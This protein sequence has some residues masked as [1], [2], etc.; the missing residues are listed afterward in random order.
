MGKRIDSGPSIRDHKSERWVFYDSTETKA[1]KAGVTASAGD[2][3]WYHHTSSANY[4]GGAFSRHRRRWHSRQY[5]GLL[6]TDALFHATVGFPE[7]LPID[8]GKGTA[9]INPGGGGDFTSL[10]I[11]V[12]RT[13]REQVRFGG[14]YNFYNK[15]PLDNNNNNTSFILY[16]N[17]KHYVRDGNGS[18]N[19]AYGERLKGLGISEVAGT[20]TPTDPWRVQ[21][22][23]YADIDRSN[24]FDPAK[25]IL[26]KQMYSHVAGT[27]YYRRD[28]KIEVGADVPVSDGKPVKA[29]EWRD[30]Y[31]LGQSDAGNGQFMSA[32]NVLHTGTATVANPEAQVWDA[33]MVGIIQ[34]GV[35]VEDAV[36]MGFLQISP[37]YR[38]QARVFHRPVTRY[39]L[40]KVGGDLDNVI[41][42]YNYDIGYTIQ[43]PNITTTGE[44][45]I[46][47]FSVFNKGPMCTG[48]RDTDG[49]GIPDYEDLD[50]DGDG[51]SDVIEAGL[52]ED[53]ANPGKLLP[54]EAQVTTLPDANGN[55]NPDV[56][57]P[58]PPAPQLTEAKE[59]REPVK[60]NINQNTVT[61]ATKVELYKKADDGTLT[62]V[63]EQT[64]AAGAT[65][66]YVT[67]IVDLIPGDVLV[68]KE[69]TPAD[70][71]SPL[72]N[73]IIVKAIDN[74]A[75]DAPTV[76][77]PLADGDIMISVVPTEP[78]GTIKVYSDTLLI[79]EVPVPDDWV[80]GQP[81]EVTLDLASPLRAGAEVTATH[82]DANGNISAPSNPVIVLDTM[83]IYEGGTVPQGYAVIN[84]EAEAGGMIVGPGQVAA[85]QETKISD[86]MAQLGI[87]AV[88]IDENTYEANG[89]DQDIENT[90]VP[91]AG[92][93]ITALFKQLPSADPVID[94]VG[95]L[96]TKVTGTGVN[97][98]TIEVEFPD[99]TKV[100]TTVVDGKWSVD[101]PVGVDLKVD[102]KV[103]ATQ[104]EDGKTTA[105]PVETVVVPNI[106][107]N[108]ADPNTVPEGYVKGTF[109][110]GPNGS[111]DGQTSP[112]VM[113]AKVN[114]TKFGDLTLP[115]PV[116][117][118]G[119]LSDDWAPVLPDKT[120]LITKNAD[121]TAVF[122]KNEITPAPL[123]DPI[124]DLDKT[125]TAT[126]V[127]GAAITGT[128]K[129]GDVEHVIPA[130]AITVDGDGKVTID[131]SKIT[132]A[133]EPGGTLPADAVVSLSAKDGTKEASD[134]TLAVRTVTPV[135][136]PNP[137]TSKDPPDGYSR[138]TL[139]PGNHGTFKEGVVSVF[140]VKDGTPVTAITNLPTAD[141]ITVTNPAYELK[142]GT[143]LWSP[144]LPATIEDA[145]NDRT[146]TAQYNQLTSAKPVITAPEAGTKTVEGTGVAG[147]TIVVTFPNG[148]KA[149]TTVKDDGTWTV[150]S[151]V[152]LKVDE[153]INATQTET[154]KISADA[155]EV[156]VVN[157]KAPEPPTIV[158]PVYEGQTTVIV[159]PTEVV[160]RIDLY[161][162]G[163]V[164]GS[165]NVTAPGNVAV[166]LNEGVTLA[167][168]DV[169]T[170]KH[171]DGEH[172]SESDPVTVLPTIIPVTDPATTP[173]E[174]F[175]RVT[176]NAADGG[177]F[178]P[179]VV[180]LFDVK[181]G[182]TFPADKAPNVTANEHFT[183]DGWSQK[184]PMPINENET[185]IALYTQEQSTP[186]VITQPVAGDT[187][188]SGTST[189]ADGTV[190]TVLFPDGKTATAI[191]TDGKWTADVPAGTILKEGDKVEAVQV[192]D[193]KAK[194]DRAE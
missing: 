118:A 19:F 182:T 73:E 96:D 105:G 46:S 67:P 161:R 148:S 163:V 156:A 37:F 11:S 6:P 12:D 106:I 94:A 170:A 56:T 127:P 89:W 1:Q 116:P 174:G 7:E 33:K 115:I 109:T 139:S 132:G 52:K 147:S 160:G 31:F 110:A 151:P 38:Y 34:A 41:D 144:V 179:D 194:S 155:D 192:E 193:G 166:T 154:G 23:Y 177:T 119:Y 9:V 74:T 188:V 64:I 86:I 44:T 189:G 101:V 14:G 121:Y 191:V 45:I 79:A 59:G 43:H 42:Q 57:E 69:M 68:A 169:L 125:I 112:V 54:G 181:V 124:T 65:E 159:T 145:N 100:T 178:A 39:D 29:Y 91:A 134:P 130:D 40:I 173:K 150:E 99:G 62:K 176:F 22:N 90:F 142:T 164:I 80:P 3:I 152:P 162:D 66:V 8:P 165:A 102:D 18:E 16:F 47:G 114:T 15:V 133:A 168:D 49:D 140:D 75:P 50:S 117:D 71:P 135:V 88:V 27:T 126:T 158:E 186:P 183:F 180:S 36:F 76:N 92:A 113:F 108:P 21:V 172:E 171:N 25:D 149:T 175:V 77:G 111:F 95:D 70:N 93:T 17:G 104:T 72:S 85:K 58:N 53:P 190:V 137:D 60:I 51:I 82:T 26:V 5:G 28:Y 32:D 78:G 107:Y 120:L 146:F 153:K 98:S 83:Y 55:G 97:G 187:S 13:S 48:H 157:T 122:I 185:F 136:I 20:G 123:L 81:V 129:V 128:V 141:D 184:L 138:I 24:D 63:G 35:P 103:K 131:I 61:T 84:F 2:D 30:A 4:G 10:E 87:S 167:A 143:D